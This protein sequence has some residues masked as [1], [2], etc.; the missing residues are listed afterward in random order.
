MKLFYKKVELTSEAIYF[1]SSLFLFNFPFLIQ[2]YM[3]I[4]CF[5]KTFGKNYLVLLS[6]MLYRANTLSIWSGVFKEER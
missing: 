2:I 6:E 5:T 4:A 1:Y 3:D